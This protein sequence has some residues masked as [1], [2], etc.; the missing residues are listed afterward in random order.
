MSAAT[1]LGRPYYGRFT[2]AD[3]PSGCYYYYSSSGLRFNDHPTGA[4]G[5]DFRPLCA[6]GKPLTA[7]C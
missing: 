5:P 7:N 6:A 4:P 1:A 3:R 2:Y